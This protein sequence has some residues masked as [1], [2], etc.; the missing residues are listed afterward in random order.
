MYDPRITVSVCN[1]NFTQKAPHYIVDHPVRRGECD[2]T[3]SISLVRQKCVVGA[4][5]IVEYTKE[6]YGINSMWRM[7]TCLS[8]A[9]AV[10]CTDAVV[11]ELS[12]VNQTRIQKGLKAG[13]SERGV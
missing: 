7:Q 5:Y 13:L 2:R 3:L 1:L 11:L 10:A 8:E 6:R 12:G 4:A 9:Y